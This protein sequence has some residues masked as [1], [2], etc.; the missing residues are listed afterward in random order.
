MQILGKL[1]MAAGIV[2]AV[3]GVSLIIESF[4]DEKKMKEAESK[5]EETV[6]ETEEAPEGIVTKIKNG[7]VNSAIKIVSFGVVHME[8]LK[9]VAAMFGVIAG[10]LEIIAALNKMNAQRTIKKMA[11]QTHC[12]VGMLASLMVKAESDGMTSE[13]Y[14]QAFKLATMVYDKTKEI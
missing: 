9:S 4:E 3:K 5:I 6:E 11:F 8:E 13:E 2:I 7:L 14:E 12:I 10:F 1:M